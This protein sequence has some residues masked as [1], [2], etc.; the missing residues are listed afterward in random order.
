MRQRKASILLTVI[1]RCRVRGAAPGFAPLKTEDGTNLVEF[2]VVFIVLM[3]ILVRDRGVWHGP[4]RVPFR[5]AR[6]QVGGQ[7]GGG[8]RI[9]VWGTGR[10]Q[11]QR[12]GA[13]ELRARY[14]G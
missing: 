1:P 8:E 11:L 3:A 2:A 6:I 12:H 9:D 13:D 10:Q 4:L 14:R 7:V 5:I